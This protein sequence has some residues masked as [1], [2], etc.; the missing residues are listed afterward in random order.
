MKKIK[1]SEIWKYINGEWRS[2]DDHIIEKVTCGISSG[3]Q[4]E[5]YGKD[6]IIIDKEDNSGNKLSSI[7]NDND[8][9]NDKEEIDKNKSIL[10]S[11]FDSYDFD[12]P[13]E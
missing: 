5:N 12:K 3:Q 8:N 4:A 9:D 2:G 10:A 11:M 7:D 6:N 13:I 1:P